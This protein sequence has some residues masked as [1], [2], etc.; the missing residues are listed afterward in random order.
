M[1]KKKVRRPKNP[2][3][4]NGKPKHN[5]PPWEKKYRL[6][7]QRE[8]LGKNMIDTIISGEKRPPSGKNKKKLKERYF[9]YRS[10]YPSILL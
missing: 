3:P 8:G 9:G 5:V 2:V 7:L 6:E 10:D 1:N 4:N